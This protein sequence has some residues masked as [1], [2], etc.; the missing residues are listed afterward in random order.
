M[1]ISD[2]E[3]LHLDLCKDY[4]NCGTPDPLMEGHTSNCPMNLSVE[5]LLETEET[6][7]IPKEVL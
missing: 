6:L 5:I 3:A 2:E 4:C 1:T 7:Q